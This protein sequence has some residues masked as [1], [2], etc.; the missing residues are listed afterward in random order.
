MSWLRNF[1]LRPADELELHIAFCAMRIAWT[2]TIFA[3]FVWSLVEFIVTGQ[4]SSMFTV[5]LAGQVV[6]FG[7]HCYYRRKYTKNEK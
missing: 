2:F 4:L 7:T 6:F 3:L 1:G 5:F